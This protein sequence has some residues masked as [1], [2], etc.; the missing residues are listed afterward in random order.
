MPLREAGPS[1]PFAKTA[2]GFGMTTQS[3][4]LTPSGDAG[5]QRKAV[6]RVKMRRG[7]LKMSLT[8]S[9]KLEPRSTGLFSTFTTRC[10][11]SKSAFC[12]LVNF[13]G[14]VTRTLT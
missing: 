12:S 14:T 5:G 13:D 11:C 10:N 2:T 8:L 4:A 7:Q 1:P 3:E 6:F 9:K